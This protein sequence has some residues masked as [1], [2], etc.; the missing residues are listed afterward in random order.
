M[1]ELST[2]R[3]VI[4]ALG[5]NAAFLQWWGAGG[6]RRLVSNW[7]SRGFPRETYVVMSD[8]LRREKRIKASPAAWGM[9]TL[10]TAAPAPAEQARA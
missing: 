1:R 4:D 3:E 5:G 10:Q 2:A 7:R 9:Q 8:R 6:D